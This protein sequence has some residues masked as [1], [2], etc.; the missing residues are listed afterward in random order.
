MNLFEVLSSMYTCTLFLQVNLRE[1]CKKILVKDRYVQIVENVF[2][3]VTNVNVKPY[4]TTLS[5]T[6]LREVIDYDVLTYEQC[7]NLIEEYQYF[8]V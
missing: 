4:Y 1:G 2:N 6:L 7:G 5:L 8:M 3:V